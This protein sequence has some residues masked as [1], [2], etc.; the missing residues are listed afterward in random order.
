MPIPEPAPDRLAR[1]MAFAL[2]ADKLKGV[3]RR[4]RLPHAQRL[5]NSAEH[6]WHIV[7][8]AVL[9]AE[10]VDTADLDLGRVLKMLLVHDLVEIDAGDTFG[11]DTAGHADKRDR[12][13][14]AAERLFGMLPDEQAAEFRALWEEF[15]AV[16]TRE[17]RFA[18]AMDR[19]QAV[20]LNAASAGG[21]WR[22][23]RVTYDRVVARNRVIEDAS[24]VLW[25]F[26]L[27]LIDDALKQG[28][29]PAAPKA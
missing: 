2:E 18:L 13:V 5:E 27:R 23:H 11:Y 3:I 22:E 29:L 12:E 16:A 6:T 28:H 8:M 15:E 25:Q 24:P 14:R 26:A 9:L 1:Q 10:H 4:T 17:A 20:M 19:L 7:L 21:S